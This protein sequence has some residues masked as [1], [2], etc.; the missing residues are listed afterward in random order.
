MLVERDM[1][2]D[3]REFLRILPRALD[4]QTW[5]LQAS[6][7]VVASPYGSIAIELG[8]DRQHTLAK[9]TLPRLWLRF[10]LPDDPAVL[11]HWLLPFERYY[12]RGG[13]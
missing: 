7:V 12:F 6:T 11:D 9:I 2:L 4:G 13:G 1:A 8:E 3:R 5:E 10:V